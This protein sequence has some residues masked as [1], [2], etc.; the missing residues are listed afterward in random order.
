MAEIINL[1]QA[2]KA[3]LR[4]HAEDAASQNRAVFGRTKAEKSLTAVERQQTMK[5]HEG[6]RLDA[7][8]PDAGQIPSLPTAPAQPFPKEPDPIR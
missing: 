2:R 6:H 1:R 7:S 5:R 8:G 3:K 4:Q